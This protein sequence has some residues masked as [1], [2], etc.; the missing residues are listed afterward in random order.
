MRDAEVAH[1]IYPIV[2]TIPIHRI[3]HFSRSHLPIL[4]FMLAQNFVGHLPDK[5]NKARRKLSNSVRVGEA[6]GEEAGI[7]LSRPRNPESITFGA[8]TV[9]NQ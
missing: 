4:L 8:P 1:A 2:L 7:H 9:P 5:S 3:L 6:E